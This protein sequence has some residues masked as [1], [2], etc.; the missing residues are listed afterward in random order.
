MSVN[1]A[2]D[3]WN[4]VTGPKQPHPLAGIPDSDIATAI[5]EALESLGISPTDTVVVTKTDEVPLNAVPGR[6]P[7]I[8]LI[9]DILS[10][11]PTT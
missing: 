3:L 6:G 11:P 2:S 1:N 8:R 7:A 9:V 5:K 10:G 4:L